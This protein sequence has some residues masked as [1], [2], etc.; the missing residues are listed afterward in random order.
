MRDPRNWGPPVAAVVA[1]GA[2]AAGAGGARARRQRQTQPQACDPLR[3][4]EHGLREVSADLRT[5]LG[6]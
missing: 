6:R 1:G 3:A 2:A 5:R 4:L